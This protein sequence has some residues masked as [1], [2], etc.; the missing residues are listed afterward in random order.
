MELGTIL[1][2]IKSNLWLLSE[3]KF[4]GLTKDAGYM[5]SFVYM[6]VCLVISIPFRFLTDVFIT[7]QDSMVALISAVM[8]IIV[9]IPVL[10]VS[11]F[12]THLFVKLL[13][14]GAPFLKTVQIFI[15]GSTLALILSYVPILGFFAGLIALANVVFGVKRIHKL[16]LLK[17]ILAVVVL[18][19]LVILAVFVLL[20]GY[21]IF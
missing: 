12:I 18:P 14:G 8:G 5:P 10:Y 4:D 2:K 6:L 19:V 1:E 3:A 7:G 13:G 17:A 16:S 11:Y 20:L 15:Y 9:S 21:L